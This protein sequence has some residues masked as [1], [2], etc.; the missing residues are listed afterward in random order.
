MHRL[1]HRLSNVDDHRQEWRDLLCCERRSNR[2]F[3]LS[4]DDRNVSIIS[5]RNSGFSAWCSALRARIAQLADQI[6]DV[7]RDKGEAAVELFE[8]L[9]FGQSLL[10]ARFGQIAGQ[11][12]ANDAQHVEIFPIQRARQSWPCQY[13][14]ACELSEMDQRY[15]GPCAA[16]RHTAIAERHADRIVR[17]CLRVLRP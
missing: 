10:A 16:F 2:S 13:D 11:L 7:M 15:N 3:I 5:A 1:H 17:R 12:P 14:K 6:F 4:T 8:L 9:A